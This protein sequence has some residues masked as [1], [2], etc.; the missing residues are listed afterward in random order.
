CT[1]CKD[2][3]EEKYDI[4]EFYE[5]IDETENLLAELEVEEGQRKDCRIGL[6]NCE[7][8]DIDIELNKWISCESCKGKKIE[9]LTDKCGNEEIARFL[10]DRKLNAKR[11]NEE[12]ARH[13]YDHK[14]TTYRRYGGDYYG[15]IRWIPFNEFGNVG[16]L[17]K[18]G[19]GELYKATW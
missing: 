7:L 17:A 13:P 18:G 14:R 2:N 9:K 10:Y 19:F 8:T 6:L 5:S 3:I 4:D 15:C 16:Y 1:N 11:G 12:F